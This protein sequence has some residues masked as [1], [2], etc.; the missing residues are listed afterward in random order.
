MN[1]Q[2]YLMVYTDGSCDRKTRKGGYG[3]YIEYKNSS[4]DIIATTSYN[5]GYEDTTISRMEMRAI[6]TAMRKIVKKHIKTVIVSDSALC[7]NAFNAGWVYRWKDEGWINRPNADLWK[8]MLV[9]ISKFNDL[10]MI[11]TRGHGKGKESYV[12]GNEM[13]DNLADYKQFDNYLA[14]EEEIS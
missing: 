8:A 9:E 11:H 2:N 14:D 6:L 1:S 5:A 12:H 4:R 10:R 13:A 7:I 3:I